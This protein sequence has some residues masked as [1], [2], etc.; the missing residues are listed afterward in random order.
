MSDSEPLQEVPIP[1]EHTK[2][3]IFLAPYQME[4]WNKLPRS[5]KRD[6]IQAQ[7]RLIKKGILVKHIVDGKVMGL[8]TRNE[9][10]QKGLI[11]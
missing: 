11:K 4:A 1:I 5:V 6:R 10:K 7:Q 2:G 8:V 3:E 9:A